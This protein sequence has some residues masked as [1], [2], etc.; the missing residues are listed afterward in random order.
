MRSMFSIVSTVSFAAAVLLSAGCQPAGNSAPT[1]NVP[2]A[3]D[4]SSE[5]TLVEFTNRK[6][7]IM[8][9]K[10]TT[11]LTTQYEGGTIGFC[12][13]GCP[14]KWASLSDEQR[15]EKFSSVAVES[16]ATSNHD[17]SDDDPSQS[18]DAGEE[19]AS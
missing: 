14:Q 17:H 13:D 4:A 11:E 2:T 3:T 1:S 18:S 7:P 5:V 10:P 12:C 9:G 6:C 8:G 15:A 16:D 19:N